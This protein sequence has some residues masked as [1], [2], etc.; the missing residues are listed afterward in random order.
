ML[1]RRLAQAK[2]HIYYFLFS[3][4]EVLFVMSLILHVEFVLNVRGFWE[5][6]WPLEA[7][8]SSQEQRA[9]TELFFLINKFLSGTF[10]FVPNFYFSEEAQF[11]REVTSKT[12]FLICLYGKHMPCSFTSSTYLQSLSKSV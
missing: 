3:I 10:Y 4:S 11:H 2:C 1:R 9:Q 7:F 5:G 12:I 8:F 6:C